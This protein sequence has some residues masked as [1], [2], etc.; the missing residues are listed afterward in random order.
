MSDVPLAHARA[1]KE[2][3]EARRSGAERASEG[4]SVTDCLLCAFSIHCE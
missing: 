4:R 2:E 1:P 3:S